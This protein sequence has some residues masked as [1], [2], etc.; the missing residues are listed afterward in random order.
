MLAD[1]LATEGYAIVPHA[2]DARTIDDVTSALAPLGAAARERGGVRHLLR[3]VPAVRALARSAPV[4]AI[5]EAARGPSAFCVRGI[6]FDKT[7]DANWKVI[8]HQDL[9]IAVAERAD[10]AG[11]GPW[12]EKAGVAHVQPP[13]ALLDR[14]VAVRVHL[15]DCTE[16]NGP[17][18]VLPGSHRAGRLAASA[19]EEWRA[20]VEEV[21]CLLPRGGILA[22]HSLLL[23][24]SSP[25]TT[26]AHRRV[27]HLEFAADELPAGL[28]WHDRVPA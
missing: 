15:D 1:Q 17:V 21:V 6:L 4:R 5:A 26:P 22:F 18:R 7:P 14:M 8:W 27:V 12:S 9:T 2:I 13:A 11:F 16:S 25:A 10:V 3:T 24:A 23:H 28:A 20:R 19:I